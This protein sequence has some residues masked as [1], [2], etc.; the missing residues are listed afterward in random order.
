MHSS[1]LFEKVSRQVIVAMETSGVNW[2]KSWAPIGGRGPFSIDSGNSYSGFNTLILG[3]SRMSQGWS[4]N[5]F[6]TF[7]SWRRKG[8]SVAKGQKGTHITYYASGKKTIENDNGQEETKAWRTLKLYTV[9]NAEQILDYTPADIEDV[10]EFTANP[11]TAMDTLAADVGVDVRN[12]DL[13]QAFYAPTPDYV[14]MPH[15]EQFDSAEAYACTLGHEITHW[16]KHKSR[17]DRNEGRAVEELVAEMGSAMLAASL[18][19]SPTPREDH[20]TYLN[21]WIKELKDKPS[22]I[23]KASAKAQAATSYLLNAQSQ[24][25]GLAA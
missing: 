3:L 24:K 18:G 6:G 2:C 15:I 4:S 11:K 13:A 19:I 21:S 7:K 22:S 5:E 14:N 8:Y 23:Q 20:A 9:F 16:T 10:P 12:V 25:V 1:E 17:L